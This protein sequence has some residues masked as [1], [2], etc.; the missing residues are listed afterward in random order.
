MN[1]DKFRLVELGKMQLKTA[2]SDKRAFALDPQIR[3]TK[4]K[5][6]VVEIRAVSCKECGEEFCNGAFKI[7]I[8]KTKF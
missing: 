7:K 8:F 5:A 1:H 6:G 3:K 2:A 4:N